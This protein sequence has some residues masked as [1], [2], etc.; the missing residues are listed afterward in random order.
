[1]VYYV[2]GVAAHCEWSIVN[3]PAFSLYVSRR[4]VL[5]RARGVY[6]HANLACTR[7]AGK[8]T[9]YGHSDLLNNQSTEQ[10]YPK[11]S[12]KHLEQ[13][14]HSYPLKPKQHPPNYSLNYNI[15]HKK[16]EYTVFCPGFQKGRVPSEKGTFRAVN[17]PSKGHH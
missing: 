5:S 8:T 1:M 15:I 13:I 2:D 16:Y 17:G 3:L 4:C 9:V 6:C 11:D 12:L 14:I 7:T 10:R